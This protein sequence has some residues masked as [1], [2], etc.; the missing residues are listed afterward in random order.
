MDNQTSAN[1]VVSTRKGWG[2]GPVGA[3]IVIVNSMVVLAA[4]WSLYAFGSVQQAVGYY[5][6]GE[7]VSADTAEKSFGIVSPGDPIKVL[8]KLT[9]RGRE[10]VRVLG[11]DA[12]CICIVPDDL[13]FSLDPNESRDFVV[14]I[15]NPKPGERGSI[16]PSSLRFD[17]T[18]FTN[19]PMQRRLPLVIR[20]EVR[21][22]T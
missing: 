17:I 15:W 13:P 4:G 3:A 6:R 18:L 14:S 21:N 22:R 8:F 5:L 7:T 2:I 11:C 1:Y 20:G 19:D 12:S 9:N 10:P 16:K